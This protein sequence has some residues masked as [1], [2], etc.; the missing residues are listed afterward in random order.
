MGRR[1]ERRGTREE[2]G[3]RRECRG[4]GGWD[5]WEREC[6]T[7]KY[8]LVWWMFLPSPP[9]GEKTCHQENPGVLQEV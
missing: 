2:R 1:R 7:T 4:R 6:S 9:R 3:K 8:K 5:V